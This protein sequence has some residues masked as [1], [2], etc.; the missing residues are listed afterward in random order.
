MWVQLLEKVDSFEKIKTLVEDIAE[1]GPEAVFEVFNALFGNILDTVREAFYY[2]LKR[3]AGRKPASALHL[4]PTG[5]HGFGL[6]QGS[7]TYQQCCDWPLHAQRFLQALGFAP[8]L[9]SSPC[10]GVYQPDGS[11]SC[12]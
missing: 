8:H 10:T 3:S 5:G 11:A 12:H 1:K 6:C 2:R 9:P 7:T 4:Y